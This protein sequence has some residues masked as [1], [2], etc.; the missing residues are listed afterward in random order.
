MIRLITYDLNSPGQEYN[1]LYSAIKEL[2]DWIHPLQNLWF[3]DSNL[4]CTSIRDDLENHVDKDDKL[5]VSGING[6]ATNF[7]NSDTSWLKTR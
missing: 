6:W 2:G 3:V 4:S 5:F 1:E 7:S